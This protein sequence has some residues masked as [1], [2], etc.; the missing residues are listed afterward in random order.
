MAY[1]LDIREA[2]ARIAE[3]RTRKFDVDTDSPV[4]RSFGTVDIQ[5]AQANLA[6]ALHYLICLFVS[7]NAD[8]FPFISVCLVE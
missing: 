7:C 4:R 8:L 3:K 2:D 1:F 6:H 5:V